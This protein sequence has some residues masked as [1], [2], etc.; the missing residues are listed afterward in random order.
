MR[1][2]NLRVAVLALSLCTATLAMAQPRDRD[3]DRDHRGGPPA[4]E[5]DRRGSPPPSARD[6][7]DERGAG[8]EQNFR[9][10]G[11]LPTEYRSRQ[12]VVNDW[13]NHHLSAPPRGYQWVQTGADYVLAAIAT[14][15][16]AQVL[17][18]H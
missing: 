4:H 9:R 13:R 11:R 3:N 15:L 2:T 12:Y 6:M 5:Q 10:G 14:G 7:R 1:T 8:P 16:I 18:S 17:L